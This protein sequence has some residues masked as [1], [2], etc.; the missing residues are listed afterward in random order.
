[1]KPYNFASARLLSLGILAIGLALSAAPAG[2]TEQSN[3]RQDARDTKQGAKQDAR[4]EKVDCRQANQ[5]NNAECR[6][7]KRDTKQEGRTDT[8]EIKY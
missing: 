5:K 6:H 2:A 4:Q 3:Q 8:R 7:D 1:M